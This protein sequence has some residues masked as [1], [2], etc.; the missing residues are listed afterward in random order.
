V[1][2]PAS[3]EVDVDGR[4]LRL[5]NLGKVL[6]PATGFTKAEVVDYYAR[7]A[8]TMLTHL[9]GRAA[10]LRRFPN[11]V[12]G[13]S[14]YEK[15][16]PS[17]RP[18]WVPTV[19]IGGSD[20]DVRYCDLNEVAA[21]VWV[22]NLAAL[23]LH[24]PMARAADPD[25][26]TM[27]V[28]DLDPG[29]PAGMLECAEVGLMIRD[30]LAGI[31][32]DCVAKTSGSKGLQLY[33][34]LNTACDYDASSRF[35]RTVAQLLEQ[36]HPGLVVSQQR[37]ELRKGKVL[38]DWSQNSRHKTTV[39]AYS[40]RAREHPTVSTPVTW[41]EVEAALDAGDPDQLRFE[42][43]QV[44]ERVAELGDLFAPAAELRQH[45]PALPT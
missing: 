42:A 18:E 40:L 16:C 11:G 15:N 28:F 2:P 13:Q 38:V 26:P 6:Y 27:V 44:L 12:E 39:C 5:S 8:P 9:G 4:R 22:A 25:T 37:K 45:L 19:H 24:T 21:V 1:V 14:F 17:H 10:T 29:A 33:L 36:K 43:R 34:P 7:I 3:S 31:D 23:E 20:G 41:D 32:L 30:V 35:A